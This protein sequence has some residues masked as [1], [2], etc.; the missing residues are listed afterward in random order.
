MPD[1][2]AR[3]SPGLLS[4]GLLSLA[5]MTSLL[6]RLPEIVAE[7]KRYAGQVLERLE[8]ADR[9]SLQTREQVIPSRDSRWRDLL[10]EQ[11]RVGDARRL[12]RLIYGD[13]LLAMAALLAGDGA[14]PCLRGKID[15]IYIDPP[16]D[17]K[18]DYRTQI[19][20]LG[21]EMEHKPTVIEQFAYADTWHEGTKSYLDMIV[22]RLILMRE[23]LSQTGSLYI[24][25]DHHVSHYVKIIM[26]EIFGK[27]LFINEIIWRRKGGVALG[28]MKRL[29]VAT[30]TILHYGKSEGY[31]FRTVYQPAPQEYIDQQFK[32]H[33]PDGRRYMVNV[34]RSP[35]P[36]PNLMYDY[37]G[38]KMPPSGWRISLDT[39]KKWDEEGRLH[40]PDSKN[41]QIYKKIYLDEYPGQQIN[42][43][44]H[45]IST[46]KGRNKEILNYNT[47][48][49]EALISRIIELATDEGDFIADFF[50][51]SGTALAVAERLG[52][53]W[54]GVDLG[55][56]ACMITR[57][58]LIDQEAAPFL[59]QHIGDYQLETARSITGRRV[60]T[61]DLA[62]IILGLYGASPLSPEDRHL[63]RVGRGLI[64][65]D[66]PHKMTGLATLSRARAL[67]DSHQG[68]WDRVTVLGWNFEPDIGQTIHGLRDDKLEVLMIPSD[69]LD[70]LRQKGKKLRADEVRFSSLQYLQLGEVRR[71][72]QGGYESLS[73]EI[74]NYVLLSPE[75]LN[76][77]GG[78]REK[79]YRVIRDD[80]L[81]L[82]S[83]WSV[84]P[85]YDGGIFRSV[86]QDY[87]G[88][89][90]RDGDGYRVV[91]KARLEG[92]EVVDGPRCICV[93]AV[94][95]FCFEAEAVIKVA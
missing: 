40:F 87:R 81:A 42:N 84:D 9:I 63:G 94:D 67:R 93:R 22:P 32:Y 8:G 74:A 47:Q 15:L 26:D 55:K 56:P 5:L 44:W 4:P 58:R 60:K 71:E 86:W 39:M 64:Y 76:L 77:D 27:G 92:L 65:V 57:K 66:S 37:K 50:C 91:R 36:R 31:K 51:G 48:K 7:G 75:A 78:D 16:F 59:Y 21:N 12:N 90:G 83:Y 33:D 35:S 82:I 68:G 18:A 34:L 23:M 95:I 2:H 49:P 80:P 72:R 53:R 28:E 62:Q 41:K 43:H 6:E 14:N 1:A 52:R 69:L 3:T 11:G 89:R 88:N 25:L 46:L 54:I 45:D 29:S 17:S 61:G 24:H 13:N 38:Y 85:D 73:L 30:D 10:R 70:R 79:L 19:E 20:V